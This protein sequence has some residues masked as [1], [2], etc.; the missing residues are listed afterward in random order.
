MLAPK[1]WT[2]R[3][4]VFKVCVDSSSCTLYE[5]SRLESP[6]KF[7]LKVQFCLPSVMTGF[8]SIW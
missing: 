4:K 1:Q 2:I 3:V 5:Y 6:I 7:E 8:D